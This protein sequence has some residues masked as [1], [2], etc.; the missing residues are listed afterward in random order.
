MFSEAAAAARSGFPRLRAGADLRT[1]PFAP[2]ARLCGC[3]T[4]RWVVITA[5]LTSPTADGKAWR[6][7][8][9]EHAVPMQTQQNV[10]G[11]S[12]TWEVCSGWAG[13]RQSACV[14]GRA[15]G[16]WVSAAPHVPR[17]ALVGVGRVGESRARCVGVR[18]RIR[19]E[20]VVPTLRTLHTRGARVPRRRRA[21][22]WRP[23]SHGWRR[24]ANA[25][26]T[27]APGAARWSRGGGRDRCPTP[28][29]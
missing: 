16:R 29:R 13:G 23:A 26:H 2:R 7:A 18:K 19:C 8:R 1:P 25:G 20:G 11:I 5:A 10:F 27:H 22:T 14:C 3:R 28:Q 15:I 21:G 12:A 17:R 6:R 4:G 24:Q 9:L